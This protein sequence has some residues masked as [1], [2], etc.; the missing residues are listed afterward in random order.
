MEL[1]SLFEEIFPEPKPEVEMMRYSTS[2]EYGNSNQWH[3]EAV[4][5]T[6]CGNIFGIRSSFMGLFGWGIKAFPVAARFLAMVSLNWS[7]RPP[8]SVSSNDRYCH[9]PL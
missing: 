1:G 9:Q 5:S 6:E 7:V 4:G 2:I 3:W 8:K